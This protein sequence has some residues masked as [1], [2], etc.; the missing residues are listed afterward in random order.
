VKQTS[1]QLTARWY[2]DKP[3]LP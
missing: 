3:D 2:G 1:E